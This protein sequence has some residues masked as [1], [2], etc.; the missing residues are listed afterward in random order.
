MHSRRISNAAA[1]SRP[2]GRPASAPGLPSDADARRWKIASTSSR[3]RRAPSACRPGSECSS[4]SLISNSPRAA[5]AQRRRH[6]RVLDD[7]DRLLD[8]ERRRRVVPK[9]RVGNAAHTEGQHH[10]GSG[11]DGE[12]RALAFEAQPRRAPVIWLHR[13]SF[14]KSAS[15]RHGWSRRA[16][17]SS[18]PPPARRATPCSRSANRST[19]T[20]PAGKPFGKRAIVRGA[21]ERLTPAPMAAPAAAFARLPVLAS[22]AG[23]RSRFM[24]T[25]EQ[26][27][28]MKQRL[29][30]TLLAALLVSAGAAFG[31]DEATLD[32]MSAPHGGQLQIRV[33]AG[34]EGRAVDH[35]A[36][37]AAAAG[38]LHAVRACGQGF[39][40]KT[41][42]RW[43]TGGG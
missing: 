5:W 3:A 10:L 41:A 2:G 19:G 9:A 34:H 13:H 6:Q 37:Q 26:E 1:A 11:A 15:G 42:G 36:R 22:A 28:I 8:L 38:A 18:R 24:S 30:S 4:G 20:H 12:R 17:A 33:G 39:G 23:S 16:Q 14:E 25:P 32:A 29:A 40:G 27:A 7:V 21:L 31:H 35:A 43:V